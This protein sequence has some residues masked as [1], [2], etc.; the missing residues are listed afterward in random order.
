METL[1][2]KAIS[3]KK[4]YNEYCETLYSLLNSEKKNTAINDEIDLL[5]IL[6]E[7]WDREHNTFNDLDPVQLLKAL[8]SENNLTAT[9]LAKILHI[10]KGMVSEILNYRKGLS[11]NNISLAASHFKIA[12]ESL[13]RNYPLQPR[14]P[15][16][17][18]AG[19]ERKVQHLNRT[20]KGTLTDPAF[21]EEQRKLMQIRIEKLKRLSEKLR[22]SSGISELENEPAFKK[23]STKMK[24]SLHGH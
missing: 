14:F 9:E 21:I 1:K 16:T 7:K 13:N 12:Q 19:L 22:T 5:T 11:K 8:M 15:Y 18:K 10:T 24:R 23:A 6:I 3:A 20:E 17:R 2:Y 4:Q